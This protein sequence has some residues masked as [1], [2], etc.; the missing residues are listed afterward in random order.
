MWL[1]PPPPAI[2]EL[3]VII[4]GGGSSGAG[5]VADAETVQTL[6]FSATM[7]AWVKQVRDDRWQQGS[8]RGGVRRGYWSIG[9]IGVEEFQELGTVG[10]IW[11]MSYFCVCR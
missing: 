4:L 9:V 10:H 2:R 5:G 11:V 8:G 1:G 7:P 3:T 6:L